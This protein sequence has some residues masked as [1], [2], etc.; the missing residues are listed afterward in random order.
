MSVSPRKG[1]VSWRWLTLVSAACAI[2]WLT[3]SSPVAFVVVFVLAL[4][5]LWGAFIGVVKAL[6]RATTR[7]LSDTAEWIATVFRLSTEEARHRA[8]E[9]LQEPSL[10]KYTLAEDDRAELGQLGPELQRFFTKY[11]RIEGVAVFLELDRTVIA[12][13]QLSPKHLKIGA[14]LDDAELAG[15]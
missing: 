1:D 9:V 6:H 2:A 12:P 8:E 11:K 14:T 4:A 3:T 7:S 13:S 5:V 15:C 10:F